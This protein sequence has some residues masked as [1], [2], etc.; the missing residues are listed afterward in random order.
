MLFSVAPQGNP[1][2]QPKGNMVAMYDAQHANRGLLTEK[3]MKQI[4]ACVEA[5]KSVLGDEIGLG[6]NCGHVW[7]V[8][9]AIRVAG[10]VD[11]FNIMWMEDLITG[12]YTHYTLA[13]VY[14]EVT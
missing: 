10:A 4:I 8:P 1:Y 13:D 6:L 11:P 7:M 9:D 3:S 14:R 2:F 12:D 5:M